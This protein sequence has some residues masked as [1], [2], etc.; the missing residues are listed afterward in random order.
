MTPSR[1]ACAPRSRDGAAAVHDSPDLFARVVLS[2]EDD[3]SAGGAG[4]GPR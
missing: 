4:R 1:T 3:R 2:I